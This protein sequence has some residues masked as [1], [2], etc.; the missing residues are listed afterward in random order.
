MS[1]VILGSALED[2]DRGFEFYEQRSQGLGQYFEDSI[3]SDIASLSLY[4]GI[5]RKVHGFHR[6]LAS[7]FPFAIYY[8]VVDSEAR[9]RA[10]LDCRRNPNW[11]RKR[12][13]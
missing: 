10:I 5:H 12:L 2:L 8:D 4:A 11:I 9:V 1:P 13:K 3:F 7:R 6:L